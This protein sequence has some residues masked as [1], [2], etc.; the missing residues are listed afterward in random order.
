MKKRYQIEALIKEGL[1]YRAIAKNL[2]VSHSTI[3][4]EIRRN[5]LDNG[6][7][8]A[9]SAAVSARYRYQSKKK[10]RRLTK[11]HVHYIRQHLKEGWSPEQI[12]G[13]MSKEGLSSI[14]HETIY[15]YIYRRGNETLHNTFDIKIRSTLNVVR[16]REVVDRSKTNAL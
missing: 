10:N 4:R 11:V 2:E 15:Q 3:S 12:S 8:R 1:S 13:R 6:E 5:S 9:E 7:Y 16:P 14:S